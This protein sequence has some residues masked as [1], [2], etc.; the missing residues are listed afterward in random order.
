VVITVP[1]HPSMWSDSDTYWSHV[2][3]YTSREIETKV[4]NA[5]FRMLL[6]TSFVSLL[7]PVMFLS[8]KRAHSNNRY[9]PFEELQLHWLL[10]R[11]LEGVLGLE[12]LL[13]RAGFR[14]PV[15]GSRLVVAIKGTT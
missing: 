6:S 4:R 15:G 3:R 2:R 14:F 1:Q 10:N 12:R 11:A 9:D 5:G 13:I 7:L 8:R